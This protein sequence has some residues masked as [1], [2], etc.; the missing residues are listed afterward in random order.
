MLCVFGYCRSGTA[1]C[2]AESAADCPPVPCDDDSACLLTDD[3]NRC[4]LELCVEGLCDHV[5]VAVPT[6][7]EVDVDPCTWGFCSVVGEEPVC[8][9]L[10]IPDC[11]PCDGD[12]EYCVLNADDD[13]PCT[14]EFCLD[15]GYCEHAPIAGCAPCQ[16]DLDCETSIDD[17]SICTVELCDNETLTCYWERPDV[18]CLPCYTAFDCPDY[19]LD[20]CTDSACDEEGRF[21]MMVEIVG[22]VCECEQPTDDLCLHVTCDEETGEC[23]E[24]TTTYCGDDDNCT[25]DTC[26]PLTGL[27]AHNLTAAADDDDGCTLD[28]CADG[29]ITHTAMACED[30]GDPCTVDACLDGTCTYDARECAAPDL[31]HVARCEACEEEDDNDTCTR[32]DPE[33]EDS[34]LYRCV[35]TDVESGIDCFGIDSC[36]PETGETTTVLLPDGTHCNA[37]GDECALY[38]CRRGVCKFISERAC[39][40][41]GAELPGTM[42][43]SD[44]PNDNQITIIIIFLTSTGVLVGLCLAAGVLNLLRDDQPQRRRRRMSEVLAK[45]VLGSSNPGRPKRRRA[46]AGMR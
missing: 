35:V 44:Q 14:T 42:P 28:E 36:D 7:C 23:T 12:H 24:F 27:C 45:E 4:T 3:H 20:P 39:A 1:E 15:Q 11:V 43:E 46:D 32:E 9:E 37:Y 5:A 2:V 34:L 25:D 30:D 29:V 41:T 16:V 33:S 31:C 8:I 21:C 19:D 17:G 26:D 6:L 40:P 10:E 18:D 13:D 38:E 22:C